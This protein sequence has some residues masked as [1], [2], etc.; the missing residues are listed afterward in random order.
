MYQVD[1]CYT[2]TIHAHHFTTSTFTPMECLNIDFVGPFPDGGC[3][4]VIVC[5]FTRWIELYHTLDAT[6]LSAA[7]CLLKH[8][9]R[10]GAP[11]H[12][13]SDNGPHSIADLIREFLLLISTPSLE[14]SIKKKKVQSNSPDSRDSDDQYETTNSNQ[15]VVYR[16]GQPTATPFLL[17]D[18]TRRMVVEQCIANL[19]S[20][21]H[22]NPQSEVIAS[23]FTRR[24][25]DGL[26]WLY[27]SDKVK[28]ANCKHWRAWSR[29]E[30]V[31]HLRL[32]YPQFSKVADKSYHEMIRDIPST[33]DLENP[34][35][36]LKFQ[37]D[38]SKT[39]D[40]YDSLTPAEESEALKILM[41]KIY[42]PAVFNWLPVFIEI[43]KGCDVTVPV[44]TVD[45]FH[46]VLNSCFE[47][48]RRTKSRALFYR[49]A[50]T[51]TFHS[52]FDE[53]KVSYEEKNQANPIKHSGKASNAS[54]VAG[55]TCTFCGKNNHTN[56]DCRTRTSEFTNN[57]NRPYIGSGGHNRL[58]KAVGD[59]N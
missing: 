52:H 45:D 47:D 39:V 4:L 36:E 40:Y 49:Y 20:T 23:S 18:E 14:R 51:G 53:A 24:F 31:G 21:F 12:L 37:A 35:L 57:Q 48:A 6:A 28:R 32:L 42:N 26:S 58:V 15:Q 1:L 8:F 56:A 27:L 44:G 10:F 5:T 17:Y 46:F 13:R 34:A 59:R 38:L 50:V 19:M 11:Y 3:I 9:G 33:Y 25:Q 43:A 29:T 55:S 30:F 41:G 54:A 2:D 7:E 22:D 16:K